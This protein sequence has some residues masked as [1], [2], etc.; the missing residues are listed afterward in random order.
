MKIEDVKAMMGHDATAAEAAVMVAVLTER[1]L[2]A[3]QRETLQAWMQRAGL[4]ERTP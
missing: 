1:S 2:D 3:G 4:M